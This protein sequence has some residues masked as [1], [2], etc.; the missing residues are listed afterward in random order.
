MIA[1]LNP[2]IPNEADKTAFEAML[3]EVVPAQ[4]YSA[5]K[6]FGDRYFYIPALQRH[7]GITHMFIAKLSEGDMAAEASLDL[8][9]TLAEKTIDKYTSLVQQQINLH[10]EAT[11]DEEARDLQLAYHSLYL[12]Q[13]LTLDRGTTHGMLAHNENDVGILASLPSAVDAELLALW[14]E[15]MAEPQVQ[16]LDGIL[17]ALPISSNWKPRCVITDEVRAS[18][19]NTVRAHYRKH[20]RK[21]MASQAEMNMEFWGWKMKQI[22]PSL[23]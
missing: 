23:S 1:D 7:R 3:Q 9:R 15:K 16:L 10:P 22:R 17:T 19:A 6:D 2:S 8:A 21:A 5:A 14:R 20:G 13:V 18:L 11:V 4:L 12:F